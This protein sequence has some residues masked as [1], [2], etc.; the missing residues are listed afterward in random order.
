MSEAESRIAREDLMQWIDGAD[1]HLEALRHLVK[2]HEYLIERVSTIE[3]ENEQLRVRAEATERQFAELQNEV[4]GLRAEF[5][6]ERKGWETI[7]GRLILL[8]NEA[9]SLLEGRKGEVVLLK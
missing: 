9:R 3:R 2:D 7:A 6:R 5:E 1:R 4:S 8:S